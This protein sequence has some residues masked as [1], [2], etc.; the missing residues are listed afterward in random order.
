MST[1]KII[2]LLHVLSLAPTI[3]YEMFQKVQAKMTSFSILQR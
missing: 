2:E 1:T 3:N